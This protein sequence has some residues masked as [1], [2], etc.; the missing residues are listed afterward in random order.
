L[1][2]ILRDEGFEVETTATGEEGLERV[3]AESFDAVLLD[4]WLTGIDGLE[5]LLRI[6]QRQVDAAVVMISGHATLETAVRATKL[7]AFDFVEKPLSLER[8]LL[9]L[10]NALRQRQLERRTRRLI[11]QLDRDTEILGRSV[12]AEKLRREVEAAASSDAPV[13]VVGEWGSGRETVARRVHATSSRSDR[14]FVQV[15]CPALVP[16]AASGALFGSDREAGRLRLA[17]GGILFLEDVDRLEAS[18]QGHL[19]AAM[20]AGTEGL[21]EI[22]VIASVSPDAS[23]LD[24]SLRQRLEVLRVTVPALRERREDIPVFIERFMRELSREYGRPPKSL[25]PSALAALTAYGWPGNV[26]E[27]RNLTERLLLLVSGETVQAGDLPEELGGHAAPVEDLYREFGSLAEGLEAFER[28]AVRRALAE[29]HYDLD[30][31]ARR[32][33]LDPREFLS[34]ARSLG[35]VP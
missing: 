32:L 33:R 12:A 18:V 13:L 10:R 14:A 4:V 15:P 20:G 9:V 2:G 5:T 28:H 26:V 21:D 17:A 3:L 16:D 34:R 11:E 29:E 19:A 7:G 23:R 27:L 31:A 1:E 22:R 25:S 24:P 8:T 30:A 35:L 6:R